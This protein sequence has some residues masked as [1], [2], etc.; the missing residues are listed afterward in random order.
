MM[1]FGGLL[2]P[3]LGIGWEQPLLGWVTESV[4]YP[5]TPVVMTPW[6]VVG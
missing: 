1:Y 2:W 4:A 3:W 5:V 6:G